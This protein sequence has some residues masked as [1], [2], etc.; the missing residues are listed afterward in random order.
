[1]YKMLENLS[2]FNISVVFISLVIS[3]TIHEAMH[4]YTSHWLGDDT[5]HREG[6]I[7]LNP[8]AHVDLFSTVL[9]PL[10]TLI[11][12]RV[13]LLAAKPVPFNPNRVKYGEFGVAL[14]GIAGP[15]TNVVLAGLGAI[16][17]KLLQGG[18]SIDVLTALIIFVQI[19]IGLFIFNMIPIPPLDG[20]RVLYAFAP[21]TLQ[22]F[23][24]QL[25]QFGIFIVFALVLAVPAFTDMLINL[26]NAVFRFLI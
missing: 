6:R 12:F 21:E 2:L 15:L 26:N 8:F 9:L 4:A 14:V 22:R 7:T 25:E 3:I 1:M 13:P 19:N 16:L 11:L 24:A 18:V 23:M 20:S 5:A 10:I 17:V